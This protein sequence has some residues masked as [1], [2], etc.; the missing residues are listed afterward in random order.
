[1]YI[2]TWILI[3]IIAGVFYYF[4]TKRKSD[5]VENTNSSKTANVDNNTD[6]QDE[7]WL[8]SE[9]WQDIA[10]QHMA[11]FT[12]RTGESRRPTYE[13]LLQLDKDEF[14]AWLFVKGEGDNQEQTLKEMIEHESRT[15][16]FT[17][18]ARTDIPP[19]EQLILNVFDKDKSAETIK[20]IRNLDKVANELKEGEEDEDIVKQSIWAKATS[21]YYKLGE[22]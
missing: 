5:E 16:S 3:L 9:N 13:E 8:D 14:K 19:H 20:A 21:D 17:K 22:K 2:P 10:L 15:G 4:Y 7:D 6:A 1:M 12:K 18:T 11:K